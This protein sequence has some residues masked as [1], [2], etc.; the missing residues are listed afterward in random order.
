VPA[1]IIAVPIRHA[2]L[3]DER[4]RD[5]EPPRWL[6]WLFAALP[7]LEV[8]AGVVLLLGFAALVIAVA[9]GYEVNQ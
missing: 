7:R 8:V 9:L 2:G 5:R 3:V 6:L 1:A 4:G